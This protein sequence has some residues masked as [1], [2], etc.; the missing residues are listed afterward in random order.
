MLKHFL[1]KDSGSALVEL[2]LTV[3]MLM[4]MMIG[5]AE[6]GRMAYYAIEVQNAARAGVAYGS[7]GLNT[8]A[9]S[10]GMTTA[11]DNEAPNMGNL[12]VTATQSCVCQTINGS[13][14]AVTDGSQQSAATCAGATATILTTCTTTTAGDFTNIVQYVNVTTAATVHTMFTYSWLGLGIPSTYTLNGYAQMRV[15]TTG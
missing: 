9:D 7:Q 13:T 15:L 14:G 10:S 3:P 11:A 1:R 8:A 4:F 6:L 12:T 5:A 2:A